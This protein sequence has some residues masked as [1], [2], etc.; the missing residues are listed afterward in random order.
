MKVRI[1]TS[2]DAPGIF[3]LA[4]EYARENDQTFDPSQ[5]Y[6]SVHR[7]IEFG[8][9]VAQEVD[10]K[11]IGLI[12]YVDAHNP[13]NSRPERYATHWLVS[14]SYRGRAGLELLRQADP[15]FINLPPN[16]KAPKGYVAKAI[17]YEKS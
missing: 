17:I 1:A 4:I 14:K 7:C 13:W 3:D 9:L 10:G 11:I 6:A 15:T 16:L 5:V 8:T 12:S 2:E